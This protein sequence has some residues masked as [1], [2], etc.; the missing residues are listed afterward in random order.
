MINS[1][2]VINSKAVLLLVINCVIFKVGVE[3]DVLK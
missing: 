3:T 1:T 2:A